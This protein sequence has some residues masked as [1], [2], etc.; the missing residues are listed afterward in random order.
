MAPSLFLSL[1]ENTKTD[2]IIRFLSDLGQPT[3]YVD[4]IS[5][6]PVMPF[7]KEIPSAFLSKAMEWQESWAS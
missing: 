7:L 4:V 2:R 3:D 5:A 6:L 1:F